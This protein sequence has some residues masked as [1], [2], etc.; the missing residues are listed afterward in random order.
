[1]LSA[2][3]VD[4]AAR[5]VASAYG[6]RA[7]AAPKGGLPKGGARAC[8]GAQGVM[9]T[10]NVLRVACGDRHDKSP[11]GMRAFGRF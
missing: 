6:A 11:T 1:M 3:E 8:A 2:A 4:E 9:G 5:R 10:A 7:E